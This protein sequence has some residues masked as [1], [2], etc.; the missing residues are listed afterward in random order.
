M[1]KESLKQKLKVQSENFEKALQKKMLYCCD[2]ESKYFSLDEKVWDYEQNDGFSE[3]LPGF[4]EEKRITEKGKLAYSP[5][6][7]QERLDILQGGAEADIY[8]KRFED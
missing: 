4:Q 7:Y 2:G 6:S 1:S 8:Q 5:L 3:S